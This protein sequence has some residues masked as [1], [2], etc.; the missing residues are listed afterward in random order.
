MRTRFQCMWER[1]SDVKRWNWADWKVCILSVIVTSQKKQKKNTQFMKKK[2]PDVAG[3]KWF[4]HKKPHF[5]IYIVHLKSIKSNFG[6][7]TTNQHRWK[8]NPMCIGLLLTEHVIEL[9]IFAHHIQCVCTENMPSISLRHA[10]ILTIWHIL[11]CIEYGSILWVVNA[12]YPTLH[13]AFQTLVV[14]FRPFFCCSC[15]VFGLFACWCASYAGF[16]AVISPRVHCTPYTPFQRNRRE[17]WK[18]GAA[19][20]TFTFIVKLS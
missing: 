17:T 6:W 1:E 10:K 3:F 16:S 11:L 4:R 15:L 7:Q 5:R 14:L 8:W 13:D 20:L 19:T 2:I 9:D 12:N 18:H